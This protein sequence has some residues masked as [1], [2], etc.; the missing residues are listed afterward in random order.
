M[1]I[2]TAWV[3]L[4]AAVAV[5]DCSGVQPRAVPAHVTVTTRTPASSIWLET[6]QMTSPATGWTLRLTRWGVSGSE[7]VRTTDGGRT[8]TDVTPPAA[9][10]LMTLPDVLTPLL[11]A[12]DG[13]HAWLAICCA[14]QTATS[15]GK[16]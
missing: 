7:L 1:R 3:M 6:P 12:R 9:A 2:R 15:A 14:G 13:E 11:L 8:W 5:A 10:R 4:L 16:L